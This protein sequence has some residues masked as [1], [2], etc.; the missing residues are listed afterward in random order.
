MILNPPVNPELFV[1]TP[2]SPVD[3]PELSI[4][5]EEASAEL[6][7]SGAPW[8]AAVV[9]ADGSDRRFY[10]VR[11]GGA[12]FVALISPRKNA[13]GLDENDSYF[14]IGRHL[15]GSGLP[16]P[17]IFWADPGGGRFLMQDVG[18]CHLQRLAQ[19]HGVD[20]Y[21]LYRRALQVLVRLHER[22]PCGFEAGFCFDHAVYDPSFVYDRELEYFR[23][24]FLVGYLGLDVAEED[25][26]Q[27]FE[28]LAER[29]G[30][31]S[32]DTVIH[33]DFQSRNIMVHKGRL[34]VLDFQGMRFGPPAYDLASLLLDPYVMLPAALQERL[35][36]LYWAGVKKVF[37]HTSYERFYESYAAVRLCRNLQ[38]LGAYGFLGTVKGKKQFFR[39]IPGAWKQLQEW[40]RGPCRGAYPGLEKWMNLAQKSNKRLGS[41]RPARKIFT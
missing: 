17:K 26:R 9:Q 18:D 25:L 5:L 29:A 28:N 30:S 8:D 3:N 10:R 33:R 27:D 1:D 11:Q 19:R 6:G 23:K 21:G 24:A 36:Q 38:A 14:L 2:R 40:M 22:G 15:Y 16:V 35:L 41:R 13:E 12:H 4:L 7:L 32:C 39:F 34:W 37:Q 20:M 31:H